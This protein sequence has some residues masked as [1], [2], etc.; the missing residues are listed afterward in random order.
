MMDFDYT[1][2]PK[3]ATCWATTHEAGRW[4]PFWMDGTFPE[5]WHGRQ[6]PLSFAANPRVYLAG[7][8]T[9]AKAGT[10]EHLV[11]SVLYDGRRW[12]CVNGWEDDESTTEAR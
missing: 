2:L 11:H 7:S 8:F 9:E 1:D 10:E 4:M 6:Y 5:Y 3:G 12:D